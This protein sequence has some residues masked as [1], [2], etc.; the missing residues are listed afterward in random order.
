MPGRY[1]CIARVEKTHGKHGE[2]VAVPAHG[3]PSLVRTGLRVA[4][5]PPSLRG[6]RW[7]VV[8]S[9]SQDAR[10]GALVTLSGVDSLSDASECVDRHLLACVDDLPEDLS[11]RDAE[12][13]V[14]REVS[15]GV[16]VAA[17]IVEVMR[18]PAND[19]W[20]LR[21]ELGEMLVPVIPEVVA[22][23]PEEGPIAVSPLEGLT[24]ERA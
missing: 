21:G 15:L 1:R 9:C 6:D 22:D 12:R 13:L 2:V 4:L 7:H 20:V 14:G 18:G 5:V 11:L 8:T 24:W 16:G 3:L 23:V 17:R 19:V 10:A